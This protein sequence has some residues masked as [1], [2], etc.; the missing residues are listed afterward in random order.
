MKVC[1]VYVSTHHGN[2]KTVAEE[3]ARAVSGETV[4][5]RQTPRPELSGYDLVGVASGV[6]F[7]TLHAEA[8]RFLDQTV[9][10]PGQR[11]FFVATCGLPY[12][13]YTKK[14]KDK[15]AKRGVPCAGSFQCRGYDTYGLF[16][17]LGGIAKGHPNG[18]DLARARRF[19]QQLAAG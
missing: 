6:Y 17:R 3:M 10:A 14:E 5:L 4:D 11:V 8:R 19:I 16:G 9:F 7:Q 2:T 18:R 13:D 1:I 15:L 12:R